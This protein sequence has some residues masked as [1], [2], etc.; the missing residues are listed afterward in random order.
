[1]GITNENIARIRHVN[2]VREVCDVLTSNTTQEMPFD[3]ENNYAVPFEIADVK[4][5]A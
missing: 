5:L 3:V 4:L 2:A 1:M